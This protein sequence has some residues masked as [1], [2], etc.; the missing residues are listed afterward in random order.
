MIKYLIIKRL[1]DFIFAMVSIIILSPITI[2]ISL[3]IY[4]FDNG[5]IIY[6]QKRVGKSGSLFIIY[7][8]RSLPVNTKNIPSDSLTNIK[9]SLIGRFIRRTNIDELPQLFNIIRGDMSFVGPRP[10]IPSQNK[11]IELRHLNGSIN[12]KPG[13]TGLAQIN[14]YDGMSVESKSNYDKLYFNKLNFFFDIFII[15]K[16]FIYLT[17]R[18][19]IY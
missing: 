14:G 7:K 1:F 6:K 4:F 13:L 19:P 10:P 18:P 11:L 3:L 17:K 9:I 15:L 2:I 5:P 12:C 16:T 8:F